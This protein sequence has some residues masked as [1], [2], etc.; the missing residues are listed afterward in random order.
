MTDSKHTPEGPRKAA[1]HTEQRGQLIHRRTGW[2]GR[3]YAIVDGERV[4]V[5]RALGT[6]NRAV[7]RAKI[8]RL[9]EEQDV[10][11]AAALPAETFADAA[12]RV[13]DQ[14][15]T[16]GMATWKERT[17]RLEDYVLPTLGPILPGD[18]RASHVRS[19]LEAARDLGK[20]RQT[21]V[22]IKNDISAV[23]GDLWRADL[24]PENVTA[25]VKVP[26][27]QAEPT[28]RAKKER[29]VLTDEELARYLAWEHPDQRQR[30]AVLERQ[31]MACVARMFGGL[32]TS[33]LHAL[34]WGG[35]DLPKVLDDGGTVGG[36]AIGIAPRRKGAGLAKG[37]RPQRLAVPEMLRPILADWWERHGRPRTGLVFPARRGAK[38]GIGTK[39]GV[40]HAAAFRRDLRRAFGVDEQVPS[41][42]ERGARGPLGALVWEQARALTPRERELFE[43]TEF[44]RPVDFHSWRRAFNQALADAG[45]NAQ[46]AQALAGHASLDAH[47]RYLVN[48]SRAREIPENALPRLTVGTLGAQPSAHRML[49]AAYSPRAREDSNLRPLAPEA[50]ALSS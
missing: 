11:P 36:F 15:R 42:H 30:M 39:Q 23:L 25:R 20:A 29:A 43:E 49:D 13:L 9:I 50:N 1:E 21:L 2:Y 12:R 27:A 37:G 28:Q 38:A 31:T 6:D 44:T 16:G 48:T 40:S 7:A 46:Q 3:F 26:E 47:A 19:V 14:Q 22:H 33:D 8:R 35:F 10:R 32:R 24:L 45:V 41:D 17:Q 4:R 5:C 18:I 34:V